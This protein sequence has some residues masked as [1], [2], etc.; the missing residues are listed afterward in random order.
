MLVWNTR[1]LNKKARHLEIAAHLKHMQLPCIALLETKVK[2]NKAESIRHNFGTYWKH[3]DNYNHRPNGRI[4]I[5]WQEKNESF[6]K[7]ASSDQFIHCKVTEKE[8][9]MV[10]WI[11][12]VYAQ[13]QLQHRR[14]LWNDIRNCA[15]SVQGPWMIIGDF[16]NVM[17]SRD[18]IGGKQVQLAEYV[19]LEQMMEDVGLYVHE[20]KGEHFTWNNRHTT[21]M[22]YSRIDHVICNREWFLQFPMSIV[23]VMQQHISDHTPLRVQFMG[24]Q[25]MPRRKTPFKFLNCITTRDEFLDTVRNNWKSTKEDRPMYSVWR[26]LQQLQPF[27]RKQA[28]RIDE[29]IR[30]I[31]NH[32]QHL[33]QAQAEL[34]NDRFNEE[35]MDRI[36]TI[37]ADLLKTTELEEQVLRQRAKV[38]WLILG[39][40]NN[41]YFHATV[42]SKNKATGIF[43]LEDPY[44]I[45][46]Q[47]HEN[48]EK[49]VIRFYEDL[50]GKNT[51]HLRHI[52]VEVMRVGAQLSHTHQTEL[53][54]PVAEKEIMDAL[55]SIGDTKAPGIDGY[56][57]KFFKDAWEIIG[58]D[59]KTAVW[60][61]FEHGRLFKAANCALVTLIP[62]VPN[63]NKMKD[64]RPIA[65]C[66][67]LYK[68]T[69]RY[70]PIGSVK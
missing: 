8:N 38:D 34:S 41:R 15:G 10:K 3:L 42:K 27:M 13:N 12:I 11:T 5:M 37:T 69:P 54:L 32:R 65:C 45:E 53:I 22:I 23:T 56:R 19:D 9:K 61:F 47:G 63:A 49:E 60:D 26:N 48:I 43:S 35:V 58:R 14:K 7:I 20:T 66:T 31:H 62:K 28:G 67:V 33:L 40:G 17:T 25:N 18:R 68:I 59:V 1:G 30:Q 51:N 29:S 50:I 44:E 57:S 36:K 16:N 4:W 21:Q 64:M 2:V 55:K 39:D 6:V 52:D 24:D 70:S 46:M